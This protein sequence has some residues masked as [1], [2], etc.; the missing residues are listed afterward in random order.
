MTRPWRSCLL[1][2]LLLAACTDARSPVAL[3]GPKPAPGA[4]LQALDCSVVLAQGTLHCQDAAPRTGG[5]RGLL[6]GGQNVYV[7]LASSNVSVVDGRLRLDVTV[8]NLLPQAMGTTD[9]VHRDPGGVKVFFHDG[10][11]GH[12]GGDAVLANED[13][14]AM[15]LAS[16]QPFFQ[17]DTILR[18]NETS[19]PK[20]WDIAYTPGV[21]RITFTVYVSAAVEH[22]A[23][24]V[25]VTPERTFLLP[26]DTVRLTAVVRDRLGAPLDRPVVFRSSDTTIATVDSAGLVR[27]LRLG[28]VTIHADSD[29]TYGG[30]PVIVVDRD[31]PITMT[32]SPASAT[33]DMGQT[34]QLTATTYNLRGERIDESVVWADGNIFVAV[35]DGNGLVRGTY[36][37]V[38]TPMAVRAWAQATSTITVRP[39]P[40]VSW[41]N[42]TAGIDFSCGVTTGSR[43]YCWGSNTAGQLGIGM[44]NQYGENVGVPV[45]GNRT[46][47]AIDAGLSVT[48]G[49]DALGAASCWGVGYYGQLGNGSTGST[50]PVTIPV[51][52]IGGE[53]F[54]QADAGFEH[55]CGVNLQG[56]AYCWGNNSYGQLGD[57]STS[58][59]FDHDGPGPVLGGLAFKRISAGRDFSCGIT[60]ED[61]LYC[62]GANSLGQ[63]GDGAS[64]PALNVPQP[65]AVAGGHKWRAVA[66]GEHACGVTLEGDAYCWGPD[67]H[68]AL[69]SG[70]VGDSSD[71]PQKVATDQKFLDIGV[72]SL[73]SCAVS[74]NGVA[75]CW[76]YNEDGQLGR[77]TKDTAVPEPVPAPVLGRV[78][79][80]GP[81]QGGGAH[82]CA[83][84]VD[85]KAYCWGR[86]FAGQAGVQ[87]DTEYCF[88]PGGRASCHTQPRA[89]T[90]PAASGQRTGPEASL[91]PPSPFPA[92]LTARGGSS[93]GGGQR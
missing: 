62:W 1:S 31:T 73:H 39:G 86:D 11:M 54:L 82:T 19:A 63:L 59:T 20:T 40:A 48:C 24:W 5:A 91:A 75:Y 38:T 30:V 33:I 21:D 58:A 90:N 47:A 25:D 79:F 42:V 52:V 93:R 50:E 44:Y 37:G 55:V 51:E 9:G 18:P 41:R 26:G 70:T 92:P 81:I 17:Y 4:A 83:L 15:F 85:G 89:V 12:P 69:G 64:A 13:G 78:V 35:V 2:A 87:P 7:R 80:A 36:P 57:G 29:T 88:V 43:G 61:D 65:V 23:D 56:A 27:A 66:T 10:P 28:I 74:T 68:G 34:V 45:A 84:G 60:S 71:V 8:Q 14:E 46:Y 3:E 67:R 72:G 77:G 22:E 53:R 32:V 76:G 6:V 49:V 16:G